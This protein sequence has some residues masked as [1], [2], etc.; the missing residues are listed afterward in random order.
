MLPQMPK[1]PVNPEQLANQVEIFKVGVKL[2][3]REI[4]TFQ[5]FGKQ[6]RAFHRALGSSNGIDAGAMQQFSLA[7]KAHEAAQVELKRLELSKKQAELAI[8][9]AMLAE[10]KRVM[11]GEGSESDR[12]VII[13]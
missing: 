7:H 4:F 1:I 2:Q 10:A 11:S 3:E 9:E 5:E 12:K 6:Y 8:A 13:S